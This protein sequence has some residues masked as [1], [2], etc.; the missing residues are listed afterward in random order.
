MKITPRAA[1]RGLPASSVVLAILVWYQCVCSI[2]ISHRLK[3]TTSNG[4]NGNEPLVV[5]CELVRPF[6]DTKN[7]TLAPA[8]AADSPQ[9]K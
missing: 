5:D 6:F 1:F 3:M 9:S 8:A 2:V 4:G 7:I